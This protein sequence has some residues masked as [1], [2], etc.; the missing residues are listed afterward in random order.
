MSAINRFSWFRKPTA[1]EFTQA[2]RAQRSSMVQKYLDDGAALS[3]AFLGAQNNLSV[4]LASL[5]AQASLQR[6]QDQV[7]SKASA[8]ASSVDKLA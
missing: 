4:G 5:A 1:W 3:N 7:N 2:W 6:V 8:A